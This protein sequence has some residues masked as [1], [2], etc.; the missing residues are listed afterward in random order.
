MG[1]RLFAAAFLLTA[2]MGGAAFAQA[3]APRSIAIFPV[4]LWDTSGEGSKPGQAERLEHATQTLKDQLEQTGRYRAVDLSPYGE[5]IAKTEPR[6]NCNGCSEPIAKE[7]GATYAL[8]AAVH[9]V[10]SLISSVDIY[11]MDL[12]TDKPVAYASGQFRGDDEQAYTRA[13]KFLVKERLIPSETE[14]PAKP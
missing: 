4:E 14:A 3:E 8:L 6:Y 2:L 11:I 5:R 1:I 12:A 13:M 10:S 9:K 7:A